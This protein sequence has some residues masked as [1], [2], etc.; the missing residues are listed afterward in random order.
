MSFSRVFFWLVS[1]LCLLSF[2]AHSLGTHKRSSYIT[3]PHSPAA[4]DL[5]EYALYPYPSNLL[6]DT[7]DAARRTPARIARQL[8]LLVPAPSQVVDASVHDDGAPEHA[9]GP[10]ELDLLVRDGAFGVALRVR[11]EVAEVADVALAVCAVAVGFGEGV[12]LFGG[13]Y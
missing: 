4:T 13:P 12:D 3:S 6:S 11:L 2:S 1:L 5:Q 10:N 7:N 9:L 8:A